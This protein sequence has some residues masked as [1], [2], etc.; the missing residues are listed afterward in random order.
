VTATDRPRLARHVRLMFSPARQQ[1]VLQQPEAV[2]VLNGS[3]AAILRLCDGRHTVDEIVAELG[4][5]YQAVPE[6][7]VRQFLGRLLA[8]RYLE[9]CDG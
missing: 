2:V 3:G 8:R 4:G 1:H 9:L 5:R 6:G 7:D